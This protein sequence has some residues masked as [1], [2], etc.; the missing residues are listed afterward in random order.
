[1]NSTGL[2]FIIFFLLPSLSCRWCNHRTQSQD[3]LFASTLH[4]PP[5]VTVIVRLI[6]T[7]QCMCVCIDAE[8]DVLMKMKGPTAVNLPDVS[9]SP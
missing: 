4:K 5:T 8:S 3:W 2:Y 6:V 7:T 9:A 1:M